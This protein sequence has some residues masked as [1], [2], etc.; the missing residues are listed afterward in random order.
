MCPP[1]R[2]A[3]TTES[4]AR[5]GAASPALTYMPGRH[6]DA[7]AGKA[8]HELVDLLAA[9]AAPAFAHHV[10]HVAE[11]EQVAG[12]HPGGARDVLRLAGDKAA[13]KACG[14]A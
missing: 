10:A 6:R 8:E 7:G 2:A 13:R 1:R 12:Q 5:A 14:L 9:H 4:P 3:L 11:H